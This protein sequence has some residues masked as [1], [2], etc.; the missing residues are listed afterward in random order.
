MMTRL[1]WVSALAV[2]VALFGC[3]REKRADTPESKDRSPSVERSKSNARS[4]VDESGWLHVFGKDAARL[5]AFAESSS[6]WGPLLQG[7]YLDVL[8]EYDGLRTPT[9]A[10]GLACARASLELATTAYV[11]EQLLHSI[12]SRV[13]E[14][15]G[16]RAGVDSA[17][18][19]RVYFENQVKGGVE[20]A[21]PTWA[22]ARPSFIDAATELNAIGEPSTLAYRARWS[23]FERLRSV[24]SP[25]KTETFIKRSKRLSSA[26]FEM[27]EGDS[28]F[29]FVDL[30]VGGVSRQF[31]ARK[32]TQ[33]L[34][35]VN[36]ESDLLRIRAA[37]L[38]GDFD[39][40][41]GLLTAHKPPQ[42]VPMGLQILSLNTSVG[43]YEQSLLVEGV[44]LGIKP[45]SESPKTSGSSVAFSDI[46]TSLAVGMGTDESAKAAITVDALDP[47]LLSRT[48]LA[49]LELGKSADETTTT[50]L[51]ARYVE[52]VLRQIADVHYLKGEFARA[53]QIRRRIGGTDA[54]VIGA[55]VPPSALAKCALEH[56]K[57]VEPRSAIRYLKDLATIFPNAKR[58]AGLLR[59]VLSYRARQSGGQT[60][61]GQ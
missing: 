6:L 1:C 57:I 39:T 22:T 25:L 52:E 11:L 45:S 4:L 19:L 30:S 58:S 60:A 10:D 18:D 40:A 9:E 16:S 35:L 51:I 3:E 38:A 2:A 46:R 37:R 24:K 27:G 55:K 21:L 54:F 34:S 53:A 7:R 41:R 13:L 28:V 15:Q 29:E 32:A 49:G 23:A 14:I 36:V 33:C 5:T 12:Q 47:V 48:I 42:S 44:M 43:A 56:W 20:L 50:T 17:S 8:T 26:D 59:D 31:F 61:A